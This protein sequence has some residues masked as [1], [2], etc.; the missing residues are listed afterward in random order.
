[1]IRLS[2]LDGEAFLLNAELIKYVE[3]RPDTFITLT[4]GERLVVAQTMD[5]VMRLTL[6]YQQTKGLV[7]APAKR[8]TN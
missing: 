5:E 6:E 8:P 1:M 2:R 3:S 7:P 4:S